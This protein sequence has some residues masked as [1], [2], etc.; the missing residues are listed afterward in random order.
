MALTYVARRSRA[1]TSAKSFMGNVLADRECMVGISEVIYIPLHFRPRR[2]LLP[3]G[4][5]SRQ[6]TIYA[7]RR[8][9]PGSVKG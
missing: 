9:K 2:Y 5:V 3:G 7:K 4:A 1:E 6:Q 8:P